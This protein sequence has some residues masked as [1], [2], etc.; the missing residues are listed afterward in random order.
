MV[1][2]VVIG[3]SAWVLL[4]FQTDSD[5][6]TAEGAVSWGSLLLLGACGG[7]AGSLIDSWLGAVC[8]VMYRCRECGKEIEKSLHCHSKAE[9]IRGASW[10]TND[11]VNMISSFLGGAV[12]I[13][14][15]LLV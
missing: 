14:L 9:R 8:Q 6:S 13:V 4:S 3:V 7:L 5:H 10:M 11:A 1:G 12:C 15:Y 2:G